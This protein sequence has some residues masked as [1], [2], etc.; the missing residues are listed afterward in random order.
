MGKWLNELRKAEEIS[1]SGPTGYR[2]NRQNPYPKP[3]SD[4]FVSSVSGS[5]GPHS[6]FSSPAGDDCSDGDRASPESQA[7][8]NAPWS[9]DTGL[10]VSDSPDAVLPPPGDSA[11]SRLAIIPSLDDLEE[12]AALVEYGAGVPREWAE[13]FAR[14]DL[15]A[16]PKGLRR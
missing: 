12:R 10:P 8:G 13:G 2:Q 15:A 16:P 3:S 6:E 1:G 7:A 14:L 9:G 11:E 5:S 4:G